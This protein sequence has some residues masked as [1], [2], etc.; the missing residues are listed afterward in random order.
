M[1]YT[2]DTSPAAP[3]A[4]PEVATPSAPGESASI[5]KPRWRRILSSPFAHLAAALLLIALVQS[6]LVKPYQVPSGSMELTLQTDGINSD[7]VLVNRLAYLGGGP[8]TGDV[9][10]FNATDEWRGGPEPEQGILR[11]LVGYFG[12]VFGFGPTNQHALVKR[13]IGTPGD[14]VECCDAEGRLLVNGVPLNEPYLHNDYAFTPG[15]E[16][17][18]TE[19][20]SRRCF[21][22]ITV[23]EGMYLMMG[24]HRSNSADSVISCRVP[25]A[26]G[27]MCARFT[28]ESAVVGEAFLVLYPFTRWGQELSFDPLSASSE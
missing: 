15:V 22:A 11:T 8:A 4:A 18:A 27:A 1:T 23:P 3:D 28:P 16:D 17:C 25:G 12:D 6:F 10:V 14:V 24:D 5:R 2:D 21:P 9:I 20:A 7:R 26:D 13:V 19:P